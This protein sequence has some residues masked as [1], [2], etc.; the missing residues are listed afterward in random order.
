M[1]YAAVFDESL[2]AGDVSRAWLVWS[3][4]ADAALADAY[5][6]ADGPVPEKGLVMGR[7]AARMRTVRLGGPMKRPVRRN[8]ADAQE[9]EGRFSCIV[10]LLLHPCWISGVGSRL[11]WMC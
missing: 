3:A 10:I 1:A 11:S 9:G 2:D 4:A 8:V 6:F 5:R 7:G